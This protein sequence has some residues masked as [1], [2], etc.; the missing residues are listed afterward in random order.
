[1]KRKNVMIN[2]KIETLENH[3]Q[4]IGTSNPSIQTL[5]NERKNWNDKSKDSFI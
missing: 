3:P 4:Y 2:Q 5:E 1:M